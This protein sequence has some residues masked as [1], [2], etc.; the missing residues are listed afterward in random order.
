MPTEREVKMAELLDTVLAVQ[1]FSVINAG[2]DVEA[3][4]QTALY[5]EIKHMV[6]MIHAENTTGERV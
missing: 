2:L 4:K 5:K 3:L 6:D 1:R